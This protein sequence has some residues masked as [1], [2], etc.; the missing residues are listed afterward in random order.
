[1][2]GAAS[3]GSAYA[4]SEV[5]GGEAFIFSHFLRLLWSVTF[6]LTVSVTKDCLQFIL[7][8]WRF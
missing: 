8:A 6:P 2:D 1:M 5:N 3:S 4:S 7:A